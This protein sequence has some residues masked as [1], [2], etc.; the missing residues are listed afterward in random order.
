MP[1]HPAL[2]PAALGE[3]DGGG[4]AGGGLVVDGA[5][6]TSQALPVNIAV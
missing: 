6:L 3:V 2:R 5:E 1:G 4:F